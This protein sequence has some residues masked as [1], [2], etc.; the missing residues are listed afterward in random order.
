MPSKKSKWLGPKV[1][2]FWDQIQDM[3][4]SGFLPKTRSLIG[5][6][7][8]SANQRPVFWWEIT[9]THVLIWILEKTNFSWSPKVRVGSIGLSYKFM[10]KSFYS[11]S[12]TGSGLSD[13]FWKRL[14]WFQSHLWKVGCIV[15][16][17][18]VWFYK[19]WNSD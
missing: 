3:S 4:S 6:Q 17:C 15:S 5:R 16:L 7:D 12:P 1:S 14:V 13:L 10:Y 11:Y 8:R 18:L 9:W 19:V 2:F